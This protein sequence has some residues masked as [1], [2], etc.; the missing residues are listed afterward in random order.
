MEELDSSNDF[1]SSVEELTKKSEREEENLGERRVAC[2]GKI[3]KRKINFL[4]FNGDDP[5]TWVNM[6]EQYFKHNHMEGHA[7][8]S[9]AT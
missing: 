1:S 4:K 9:Y 2:K 8:V 7:K 5:N 3:L 6:V